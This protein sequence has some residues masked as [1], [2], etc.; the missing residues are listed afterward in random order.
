MAET[1]SPARIICRSCGSRRPT[2]TVGFKVGDFLGLAPGDLGGRFDGA[3]DRGGLVAVEPADRRAYAATLADLVRGWV[4]LAVAVEHPPFDGGKLGPPFAVP[5]DAVHE[6]FDGAFDVALLEREDRMD[7]EP[8]WRERGA[9][10]S[11]RRA[12][13]RGGDSNLSQ[14]GDP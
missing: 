12:T 2:R 10:R 7:A 1:S 9:T 5:E 8:A 11:S 14:R 4:L 13:S 6:L 3:F